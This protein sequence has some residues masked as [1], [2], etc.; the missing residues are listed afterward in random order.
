MQSTKSL[1]VALRDQQGKGAARKLRAAA[2]IPGVVYGEGTTARPVVLD[3][4]TFDLMLRSG[5]HHGLLDLKFEAGHEPVKALV[6][7]IQVHPVSREVVHVDLQ[8]IS[9][10]ERIRLEVPIVL[11]GKPEGV[12]TQGGILE[13]NLRNVEVECL[14][15][16]IPEKIEVDVSAMTLGQSLHVSDLQVAGVTFLAHPDTTIATVSI[17]AAEQAKEEVAAAATTE[18]AAAP[19]EGEAKPGEKTEAKPAAKAAPGAAAAKPAAA[20]A[21]KPAAKPGGKGGKS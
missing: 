14:P 15:T 12:K 6:R 21:G 1:T 20:P 19:A 10:K 11:T 9:M 4:K 16:D 18:G 2:K 7:E 17:P 3:R 5:Q 13:H 8:R